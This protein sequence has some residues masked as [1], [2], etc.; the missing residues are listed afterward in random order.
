VVHRVKRGCK[1]TVFF[2]YRKQDEKKFC[3]CLVCK[4]KIP[5]FAAR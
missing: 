2:V 4:D 5:N 1:N 3:F